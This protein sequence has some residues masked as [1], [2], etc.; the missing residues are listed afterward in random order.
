VTTIASGQSN[1]QSVAVDATTVYWADQ[2]GVIAKA[3]IGGG[4]AVTLATLTSPLALTIDGASVYVADLNAHAIVKIPKGGGTTTNLASGTSVEPETIAVDSAYV[5]WANALTSGEI[6]KVPL[7]GGTAVTLA[8]GQ[9][10]A[11]GIAVDATSVY[12]TSHGDG[13]V[14]K[15][16]K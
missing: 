16:A 12:W 5:Y 7:A 15:V 10:Y 2:G 14:K 8:T 1:P 13:T 4:T 11:L 3:P 6:M 9:N